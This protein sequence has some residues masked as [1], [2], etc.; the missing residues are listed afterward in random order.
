MGRTLLPPW[1]APAPAQ[2]GTSKTGK[3]S[4]DQWRTTAT[5]H[6][7]TTLVRLW[8][9][10]QS[11]S[12]R[13]RMLTNFMDLVTATKLATMRTMSTSRIDLYNLHMRRYLK[14]YLELYQDVGLTPNQ[15]LSLHF[16]EVLHNFGP[17]HGW[18][19]WV[20]ERMNY[21]LQEVSTNK[22]FGE[23]VS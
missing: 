5:V 7:V 6:L 20:F 1:I 18:R 21:K 13:Y 15:H 22:K 23:L 17:T 8:G 12:R 3:L 9:A 11:N 19:S 2:I 10:N 16:G 4:A 14:N